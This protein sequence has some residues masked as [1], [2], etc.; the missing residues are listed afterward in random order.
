ML[1]EQQHQKIGL[2][3]GPDE[4]FTAR[5]RMLGY[6]KALKDH[7][8]AVDEKLICHGDYTIQ[9]GVQ[10]VEELVKENPD[11]TAVF[12]TNYEMTM[13][14]VIGLNEMGVSMP[15]LLYTSIADTTIGR[16]GEAAACADKFRHE[17]VDITVTV[18][19]CW[20]YGAATMDMDPQTIKAVW[21]F[22]ATERPGA[23]YL[24]SVLATHAQKGLPAF[25][26]LSLIHICCRKIAGC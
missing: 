13:G 26:I 12:V 19:P 16:V 9:G 20:C 3:G 15:C 14:A 2:I 6:M 18:T 21:G 17:G 10:A 1:V 25:G 8:I 7:G 23:V 5:Q 24:A 22:N 4:V 11:M